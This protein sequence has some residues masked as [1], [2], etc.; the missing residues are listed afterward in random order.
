MVAL[1]WQSC[2]KGM[3]LNEGMFAGEGGWVLKPPGYRGTRTTTTTTTTTTTADV[4]DGMG[5][6]RDDEKDEE[7]VRRNVEL[8]LQIFA[9]QD[10]PLPDPDDRP[11]SFRP[12]V[13]CKL[14]VEA[15]PDEQ[16]T[17]TTTTSSTAAAAAGAGAGAGAAASEK[18]GGGGNGPQKNYKTQKTKTR[19]GVHP[20]FEGET[21]TFPGICGAVEG[22]SF[23]RSVSE[24][25]PRIDHSLLRARA[26]G[27]YL[28]SFSSDP[29]ASSI[30]ACIIASLRP[31][32]DCEAMSVLHRNGRASLSSSLPFPYSPPPL[33]LLFQWHHPH[34]HHHQLS[35]SVSRSSPT[36][37]PWGAF[38][39]IKVKGERR[40]GKDE[41]AAWACIRL[42][43]LQPGFRFIH[44]LDAHA[45][46][47]RGLLLVKI[48]KR[49]F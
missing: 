4:D 21:L 23:L 26:K 34:H 2:D 9:A 25:R 45:V 3:M 33:P 18:R 29:S 19:K 49:L 14:H 27:P 30:T 10:L 48:T 11:D 22:L 39:R 15:T 7:I 16:P 37:F 47:S 1:N 35:L 8:T 36:D 40:I 5:V 28:S 20:D 46:E 44:L 13:K 24:L 6:K 43:R 38:C 12:C 32:L 42:D 31:S 41:L 17:T